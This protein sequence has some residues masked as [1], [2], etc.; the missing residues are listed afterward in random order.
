MSPQEA[1]YALRREVYF[2]KEETIQKRNSK[3]ARAANELR[4]AELRVLS[5]NKSPS[6]PGSPPGR[7]SGHLRTAWTTY[8][9]AGGAT[10]VFGIISGAHYAGYLEHGTSKMAARP[11]VDKIQETALPKIISIFSE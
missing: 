9:T 3:L 2:R 7:R 10:G 8:S 11:Y 5:G 4:N 6:P 1:A